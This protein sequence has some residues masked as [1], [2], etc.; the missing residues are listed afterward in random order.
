VAIEPT[1]LSV[2]GVVVENG[3]LLKI[4]SSM[5]QTY[6]RL[7]Q[8]G[9]QFG[10]EDPEFCRRQISSLWD[11]IYDML[12]RV[13]EQ[14]PWQVDWDIRKKIVVDR[15]NQQF[16]S[17]FGEELKKDGALV[18]ILEQL[19]ELDISKGSLRVSFKDT[20]TN[21]RRNAEIEVQKLINQIGKQGDKIKTGLKH[22]VG[23]AKENKKPILTCS[24]IA[25]VIV[26][27]LIAVNYIGVLIALPRLLLTASI[28]VMC[29]IYD[30]VEAYG[31]LHE[32]LKAVARRV[33]IS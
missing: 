24:L 31:A 1:G 3:D 26:T 16:L 9:N 21:E 20:L 30:A 13:S 12:S 27:S 15:D 10:W 22:F 7:P 25:G 18:K 5:E 6:R 17:V 4:R 2:F 28:A 14:E 8:F 11:A 19:Q 33:G 32:G 29:L 23:W